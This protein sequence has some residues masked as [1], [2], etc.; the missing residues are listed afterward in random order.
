MRADQHD[1]QKCQETQN[2]AETEL[3]RLESDGV[4]KD[5]G[6]EQILLLSF[7]SLEFYLYRERKWKIIGFF[8]VIFKAGL[9][10]VTTRSTGW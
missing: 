1:V 8:F 6:T 10:L 5:I 4:L 3:I 2:C 7:T 9:F